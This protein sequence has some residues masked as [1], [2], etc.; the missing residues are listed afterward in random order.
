MPLPYWKHPRAPPV[1]IKQKVLQTAHRPYRTWV[2]FPPAPVLTFLSV[3]HSSTFGL[4]EVPQ[5]RQSSSLLIPLRLVSP[6]MD[7]SSLTEF[8]LLFFYLLRTLI[9]FL[10]GSGQMSASLII[11]A[12]EDLVFSSFSKLSLCGTLSPLTYYKCISILQLNVA[13]LLV[14]C[15]P[16]FTRM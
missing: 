9:Y 15:L 12:E 3:L 8:F 11:L 4:F 10:Q 13:Y 5:A 1:R 16:L 2:T 7:P 14:F 6:W